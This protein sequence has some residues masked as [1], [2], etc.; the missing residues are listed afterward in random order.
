MAGWSSLPGDLINRVADCLLATDDLDHYMDFRAVCRSWPSSTA[1]PRSSPRDPRFLPRQWVMLDEVHQT[2]TRLFV[3]VATGRFVRRDLPLLRRYFVVAGAAGGSVV[4]AERAS[5]HATGVLNPFTGSLLRFEAPVPSETIAAAHV[6]G[7]SPPTLVLIFDESS[8]ITW[9]DPDSES[10]IELKDE[11]YIIYPPIKLALVG[12][13]YAAAHEGGSLPSL[14]VP[15]ANK[16]LDVASKPIMDYFPGPE[17]P[18]N[19]GFFVESEGEMLM[20]FKVPHRIEVFKFDARSD[21]LEPVKDLGSR[22]L[23]LGDCR[24][25]SVDADKLPSVEANC[26]YYVV[27]EEPWYKICVYSL[28]DEMEVWASEA[29]DS[30][31]PITLSSKVSSPFTVVQLLCSYTFEV[32]VRGLPWEKLYAALFALDPDLV[33]RRTE[34]FLAYEYD[35]ES[36]Y[37]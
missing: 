7:S 20:V 2:D 37:D 32:R 23:F 8:S 12:G 29:I 5:P 15:T 3:N 35:S 22:A 17:A 26:I 21:K 28:K 36:E 27:V 6:V 1:D 34:E 33:A 30:F 18:E 4:L 13:I 11:R 24:C 9:A 10:F 14:L 31:N 25:L 16:I 19:R